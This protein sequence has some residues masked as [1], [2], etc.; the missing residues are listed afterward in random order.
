MS[1]IGAVGACSAQNLAAR[2]DALATRGWANVLVALLAV[3][4]R[5]YVFLKNVNS[6]CKSAL[7]SV[8]VPGSL[9]TF[10]VIEVGR[11]LEK[12]FDLLVT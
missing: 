5:L 11:R 9:D 4:F 7:S 1:R 2:D 10:V 12:P 6:K 3:G 8:D